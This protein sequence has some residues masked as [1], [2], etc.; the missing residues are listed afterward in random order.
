MRTFPNVWVAPGGGVE[1]GETLEGAAAREVYEETGLVVP[2]AAIEI[3][4]FFESCYPAIIDLGPP[5]RHH[6]RLVVR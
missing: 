3:F 5:Q 1:P 4:G 6:V 2:T